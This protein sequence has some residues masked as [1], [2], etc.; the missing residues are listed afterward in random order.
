[1]F[2][3]MFFL[4]GN[5]FPYGGDIRFADAENSVAC[6]PSKIWAPFFAN[7]TRGICFYDA[8][9]F[10]R[11]PRWTRTHEHVDVIGGAADDQ[12]G[13]V[14]LSNNATEIGEQ[15]RSKF[16]FDQRVAFASAEDKMEK[17]VAARMRH[18]LSPLQGWLSLRAHPRL[19]PWA[20]FFRD[21]KSTRLNSSHQIISY[22]V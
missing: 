9:K 1:M 19:A 21:R 10:G 7:P 5:I 15:F 20:A 13:P 17:D 22:A 4:V 16:R 2:L 18:C 6:L 14:H 8:G 3:V 11:S 12:R